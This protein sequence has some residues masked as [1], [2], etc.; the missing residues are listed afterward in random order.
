MGKGIQPH[1]RGEMADKVANTYDEYYIFNSVMFPNSFDEKTK[2]GQVVTKITTLW[3]NFM[4]T[5]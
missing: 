2:D 3:K 4:E 1:L 5:G